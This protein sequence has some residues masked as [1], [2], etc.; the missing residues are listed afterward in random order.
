[1][2]SIK[3][4]LGDITERAASTGWQVAAGWVIANDVF[5]DPTLTPVFAAVL[6]V[7]KSA[8]VWFYQGHK[9][10]VDQ[11]V[12]SVTDVAASAAT[13][14]PIVKQ[15]LAEIATGSALEPTVKPAPVPAAPETGTVLE[16][17]PTTPAHE[18]PPFMHPTA[19]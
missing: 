8:A 15:I 16:S 7:A 4:V 12:T 2:S 5:H 9:A 11:T 3:S 19:Q 6:S 1:M 14:E 17:L 13:L 18:L 10:A